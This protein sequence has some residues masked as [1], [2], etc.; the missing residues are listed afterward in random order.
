MVFPFLAFT[1]AM[2]LTFLWRKNKWLGLGVLAIYLL[3][4]L[5]TLLPFRSFP[6]QFLGEVMHPYKTP[7]KVVADYLQANAKDGDT[8]FV[9]LDRDHEA[10]IFHLHDKIRFVNRVSRDNPLLFPENYGVLPEYIYNFQEPPDWVIVYGKLGYDGSFLTSDYR[11]VP[12]W[13]D[14]QHGYTETVLPVYFADMSRPEIGW[15]SFTEVKPRPEEQV[16]IFHKR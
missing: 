7:D 11:Q 8:A 14:L 3:T 10:L 9:T 16:F 2:I 5:F 15:R 4:N 1:S 6:M 13:L 12:I